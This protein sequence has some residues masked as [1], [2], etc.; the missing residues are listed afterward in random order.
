MKGMTESGTTSVL[1][2]EKSASRN[3]LMHAFGDWCEYMLH[4]VAGQKVTE[5]RDAATSPSTIQT[6]YTTTPVLLTISYIRYDLSMSVST[7]V[8]CNEPQH[9][10]GSWL[11]RSH[12]SKIEHM[13]IRV[14]KEIK[15]EMM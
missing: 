12:E 13:Y 3:R 6:A 14:E 4:H 8:S 7:T 5:D 11:L 1:R 15:T 10:Y 9:Y 2:A